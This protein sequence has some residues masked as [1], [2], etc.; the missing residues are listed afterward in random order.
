MNQSERLQLDKMIK[1]NDVEDNTSLIRKLKHSKLIMDDVNKLLTLKKS[2][3]R[4]SISNPSS[5]DNMCVSQC[6]FLFNNYTDI[7]NKVKKDEINLEILLKLLNVLHNI[8]EGNMDQHEGSFEVG[9]LL[10]EIYIDSAL[11]KAEKLEDKENKKKSKNKS[12][13]KGKI[14]NKMSW[15]D[16]KKEN[17]L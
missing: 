17:G 11:K 9:K 7:F 6:N 10:K 2:H 16:Y 5:F 12:N 1:A 13:T 15:A 14:V 4:L 8:E 3:A